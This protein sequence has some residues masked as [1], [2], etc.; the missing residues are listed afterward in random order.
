MVS[1][2]EKSA[3]YEIETIYEIP[4]GELYEVRFM[5][6]VWARYCELDLMAYKAN[7]MRIGGLDS[8]EIEHCCDK[9]KDYMDTYNWFV[10]QKGVL[11]LRM[12][13]ELKRTKDVVI[14]RNHD[15]N[16]DHTMCSYFV[17]SLL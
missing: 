6:T 17:K 5:G 14:N 2:T 7:M 1:I 12:Y 4:H 9:M 15:W 8:A 13:N 3:I 11:E 10:G 16:L